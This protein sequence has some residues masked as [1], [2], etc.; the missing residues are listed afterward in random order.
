M[1]LLHNREQR[2]EN[3]VR[4]A[5]YR[6][7][8]QPSSGRVGGQA[9]ERA[10]ISL[11][12]QSLDAVIRAALDPDL[13]RGQSKAR[14]QRCGDGRE[15]D[16]RFESPEDVADGGEL[17]H[18]APTVRG[19]YPRSAQMSPDSVYPAHQPGIRRHEHLFG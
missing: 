11:D 1:E 2:V 18:R 8:E 16:G 19:L 5:V 7:I 10:G 4:R 17:S 14:A 15:S 12:Q 3:L 6:A 9:L 13:V